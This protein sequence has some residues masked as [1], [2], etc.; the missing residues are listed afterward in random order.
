M[1]DEFYSLDMILTRLL[2]GTWV[3]GNGKWYIEQVRY[4]ISIENNL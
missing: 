3:Q 4:N 1:N 2:D